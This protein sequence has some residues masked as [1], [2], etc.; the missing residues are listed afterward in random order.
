MVWYPHG[1]GEMS[2]KTQ[3][4]TRVD[5]LHGAA[6]VSWAPLKRETLVY[7]GAMDGDRAHVPKTASVDGEVGR[8][9]RA[10]LLH[11]D[12]MTAVD[13]SPAMNRHI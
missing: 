6:L 8:A 7:Q 9:R 4:H 2:V 11:A 13:Q 12:L 5:I 1:D 3:G 10:Q